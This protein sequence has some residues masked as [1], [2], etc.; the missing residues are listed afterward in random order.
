MMMDH[1]ELRQD[2]PELFEPGVN[3]S[4]EVLAHFGL[5]FSSFA[6][7]EA[8]LQNCVVISGLNEKLLRTSL[9]EASWKAEAEGLERKALA[10]T[11]GTLLKLLEDLPYLEAMQ[12]KLRELKRQRD[13]FA[14]SFFRE[15]NKNMFF[16][17]RQMVLI[18]SM[19]NLRQQVTQAEVA[20]DE[21]CSAIIERWNPAR[22]W[23][24]EIDQLVFKL[25]EES[26]SDPPR[27]VGW[28]RSE[29]ASNKA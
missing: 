27:G 23:E 15:E 14:H 2:F 26:L 1:E 18:A 4:K 9:T 19:A 7:L 8:S 25:K 20:V 29:K 5:V 13:Y 3:L 28:T 21:I 10:A 17:D 12:P 16:S 22:D 24:R 11:F 6:L